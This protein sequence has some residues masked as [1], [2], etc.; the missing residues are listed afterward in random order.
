M[1]IMGASS[2]SG[3]SPFSFFSSSFFA[4]F[5]Y[6]MRSNSGSTNSF[7]SS[8]RVL[9]WT[10]PHGAMPMSGTCAAYLARASPTYFIMPE[11]EPP[12]TN[13]TSRSLDAAMRPVSSSFSFS[14]VSEKSNAPPVTDTS[15]SGRGKFHTRSTTSRIISP[16]AGPVPGMMQYS[17]VSNSLFIC[18]LPNC[19]PLFVTSCFV[20]LVGAGA[21]GVVA[22]L[23]TAG[24]G[25]AALS[26]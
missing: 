16:R 7:S 2:S 21:I 3:A 20:C 10:M 6:S 9:P 23:V 15:K 22:G 18:R 13:Q 26:C 12:E 5:L 14:A 17:D 11:S 19:N 4:T 24:A 8:N 1:G 25:A